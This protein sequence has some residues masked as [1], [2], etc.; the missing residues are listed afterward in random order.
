M[1]FRSFLSRFAEK[2]YLIHRRDEL[3]ATKILQERAFAND[4][5]EI[6]WDSVLTGIR[7][8]MFGVEKID[9]KNVKTGKMDELPVHGC[10]IWIGITPNTGFVGDA[11]ELDPGGFIIADS[12]RSEE[13]R[14]GKECRSRWS[15]Y[16]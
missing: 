13:R 5:I 4:K 8:G 16:H 2:I 14:V 11:L 1:L 9:L 15:P 3:R 10:F 7:G 12:S 6:V